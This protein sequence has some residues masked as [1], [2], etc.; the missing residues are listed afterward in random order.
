MTTEENNPS[1]VLTNRTVTYIEASEACFSLGSS[2]V[3]S[4][5]LHI[6]NKSM[7]PVSHLKPGLTYLPS[8]FRHIDAVIGVASM[9][10]LMASGNIPGFIFLAL[11]LCK[12]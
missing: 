3:S 9:E 4:H 2:K 5:L 12:V 11:I 1:T 6:P 7:S 10:C 8:H